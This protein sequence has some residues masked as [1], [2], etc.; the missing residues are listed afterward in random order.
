MS[1]ISPA[2]LPAPT[3]A[4]ITPFTYR[5][6]WTYLE[7]LESLR[8]YI[9]QTLVPE[10]ETGAQELIDQVNAALEAQNE[11]NEQ[12]I[13]ALIDWVNTNVPLI[14]AADI[15][16]PGSPSR[17]ALDVVYAQQDVEDTVNTGR[18]SPANTAHLTPA[19]LGLTYAARSTQDTVE[20]GRLSAATLNATF[21]DQAT[22]DAVATGRLSTAQLDATY[23]KQNSADSIRTVVTATSTT[24]TPVVMT[25]ALVIP[26][27][28]TWS[29]IINVA[30]RRT[31]VDNESASYVIQGCIDRNATAATTAV[32]GTIVIT[33]IA[34]DT[35]AW[36][37]TAGVNVTTGAL[38]L[39]VVGEASKTIK[40][41]ALVQIT[42]VTG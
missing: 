5:D 40:W 32:V 21:A 41:N 23:V 22:E 29:F 13:Q 30:A 25:P 3:L 9:V 37:V 8:V 42:A 24:A 4:N 17:I 20:T 36:N 10:V 33:P 2:P 7:V 18:L 1:L 16:T 31:D 26:N 38:E 34:E 14:L 35:V 15:S 27:D 11:F 19:Q 28:T 6:G 39:S 12:E